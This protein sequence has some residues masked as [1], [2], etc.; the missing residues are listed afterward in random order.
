M[1]L[2]GLRFRRGGGWRTIGVMLEQIP[3]HVIAGPLGAGK[4]SLLRQLLNQKPAGERWALLINE[5]GAI[6]LDAAL[7]DSGEAEVSF[8]EVAG[9]CLCC[10]TGVPFQ[11]GL[12]RLLRRSRPQ[13]LF[14]EPSGLGH[15]AALLHQLRKAPW[16]GVLAPQPLVL[17][18][19]AEALAAGAPLPDSQQA[20]IGEAGLLV[21]NKSAGLDEAQR[22]QLA[23]RWPES[24]RVWAEQG[25]LALADLPQA[26]LTA[27]PATPLPEPAAIPAGTL[28][29]DPAQ[30]LC[31]VREAPEGWSIGWRWHP[32][33][34]FDLPRLCD[35][36][37]G[38]GWLRAKLVMHGEHGWFAANA[39]QGAALE[40]R[41]SAWRRDSRL[42][43][44]FA[45]AQDS[46]HLNALF[47]DC[48]FPP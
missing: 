1:A 8:A 16:R 46:Q 27:A 4:T 2:W 19:D 22:A 34:C 11:V 35:R 17:V 7:L 20:V 43:L 44:I 42:E 30:P 6:G 21:L 3:T 28:W 48:R 18:L 33:Q 38:L 23:A 40:L 25:R 5:F 12:T 13:R 41:P 47:R 45:G 32:G 9:G 36:L 26:P 10:A 14:I 37:Q 24:K 31:E 15:P 29:S 39:V